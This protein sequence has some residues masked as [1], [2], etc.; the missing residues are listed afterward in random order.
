M[1]E[2]LPLG[3]AHE[4]GIV[5]VLYQG[6]D[7]VEGFFA[8]LSRQGDVA[9][10]L[11]VVDNSPT[12]ATLDR[13]R[14]LATQFGIDTEFVF[15]GANLGVAKGNNQGVEMALRDRC[16]YVLL[17]NNDVEFE[18]G[19]LSSLLRPLRQGER[20]ST[21]KI[22]YHGPQQLIWYAGGR[23]DTWTMR[24]PHIGMRRPDRGQY[25]QAGYTGYAP[26]CFLML[27][28][29]V[30][31]RV[32]LMDERYF[33]YY[34]DT[35]FMWR[36]SRHGVRVRYCPD[37]MVSHKVSTSTGGGTSPFTVYYSNR[38]RLFFIRKN[39]TGLRKLV[40]LTYA[41]LTRLPIAAS[42]PRPVAARL[43]AGVKDGLLLPTV[44]DAH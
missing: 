34:D 13:C 8:S 32:G 12:P 39:F 25:D 11:Y 16:R 27:D 40:A 3:R 31:A 37:A 43:W 18:A 33:V 10:K 30:F 6:E 2:A 4:L 22:L 9:F 26:T 21:P 36:L 23:I 5:T 19:T 35:D 28:A 17:A 29:E 15:N 42:L 14:I 41:L 7:V 20:V 1:D 38:N 24:T 44:R